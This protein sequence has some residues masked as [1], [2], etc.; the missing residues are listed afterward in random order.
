MSDAKGRSRAQRRAPQHRARTGRHR[1]AAR[2]IGELAG[3][4]AAIP[5]AAKIASAGVIGTSAALA[6]PAAALASPADGHAGPPVVIQQPAPPGFGPLAPF[7]TYG[8]TPGP[9]GFQITLQQPNPYNPIPTTGAGGQPGFV[10]LNPGFTGAVGQ[11]GGG[12]GSGP[13]VLQIGP[14]PNQ[15]AMFVPSTPSSSSG[16][17]GVGGSAR[18]CA[19]FACGQVGSVSFQ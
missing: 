14:G 5:T 7:N 17:I 8:V 3:A 2:T 13:R 10:L 6:A 12:L 16:Q 1:E 18:G 11:A 19:S 4:P 9:N 15:M